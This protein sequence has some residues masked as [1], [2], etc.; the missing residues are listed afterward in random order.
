MT[1]LDAARR[2]ASAGPPTYEGTFCLLCDERV[3]AL[4][5]NPVVV[6][7]LPHKPDCPWLSLPKIVAI[8]EALKAAEEGDDDA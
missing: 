4:G 8:L 3:N 6:P 1:L 5:A 2:I 7:A